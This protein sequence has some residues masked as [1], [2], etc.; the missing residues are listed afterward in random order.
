LKSSNH[1][2]DRRRFLKLGLASGAAAG[3]GGWLRPAS[4]L[5]YG[6]QGSLYRSLVPEGATPAAKGIDS[7]WLASLRLREPAEPVF[8]RAAN[9]LRYIGMPLGG[10]GCGT[11]YLGGDGRLWLWDVWHKG[12]VGI[13]PRSRTYQHPNGTSASQNCQNGA[14][15]FAPIDVWA[16]SPPADEKPFPFDQGF[17]LRTV[18]DGA[19]AVHKLDRTGFSDISF[20]GSYP[21]ARV[22]YADAACPLAGDYTP[23]P[24]FSPLNPPDSALPATVMEYTLHNPGSSPVAATVLGWLQNPVLLDSG[25]PAGMAR[26]NRIR[27]GT[28]CAFL[29]CRADGTAALPFALASD[30]TAFASFE[31][32]DYG[33]WTATGSAFG[34]GPVAV[35]PP[36]HPS[37][38]LKDVRG[39]GNKFVN[40]YL[41]AGNSDT[42][43][44]TLTSPAFTIAKGWLHFLL[45][46]GAVSGIR[47]RLLDAGDSS[48]LR[49]TS[50][51][52]NASTMKWRA[53]DVRD[54]AGRSVKI[55]VEDLSS[56]PWGQLGFDHVCFSDQALPPEYVIYDDFERATYAPWTATGTA[57]GSGP[58][59]I[60][61]IPS[62]QG[63]V[64][65]FGERVVNSHASAPGASIAEKDAKTGTLVSPDF[66][67]THGYLHFLQ[68]G[69]ST[70][71]DVRVRLLKA[72]DN[73]Q[74]RI[75]TGNDNNAMAWRTFDVRDLRGQ[76]VRI[77]VEDLRTGGWGKLGID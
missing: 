7:G 52:T 30:Y 31:G 67:V 34:P 6:A 3:F 41:A 75:Q 51:T 62:Y 55:V 10:F 64:K 61:D 19:E 17:A 32:T 27:S 69:G 76:N 74:L 45:G 4:A 29:E 16:T 8:T 43:T 9:Q 42:P 44:G 33:A 65:G 53:W 24:V 18:R 37:T 23:H 28:G 20:R 70:S 13:R 50:N 73:S 11:L 66:T 1:D 5:A 60:T 40:S 59:L 56:G 12:G 2:L 68:G 49:S 21:L 47:V 35:P 71:A 26:S 72:S 14:N 77:S 39:V 15:Y 57:F 63:D 36:T 48:E 25:L 22:N 38:D 58:V 46:G 54:L